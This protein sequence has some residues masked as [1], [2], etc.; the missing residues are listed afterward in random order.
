MSD[1]EL[2]HLRSALAAFLSK[3]RMPAVALD[4]TPNDVPAAAP[5]RAS[6]SPS[7]KA[8]DKTAAVKKGKAGTEP[9]ALILSTCEGQMAE[10]AKWNSMLSPT[11][12]CATQDAECA[13]WLASSLKFVVG[14]SVASSA[15]SAAL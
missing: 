2:H 12:G 13:D 15:H 1:T 7:P 3:S 11:S 8:S 14:Q 9:A 4:S 5:T 10:F 6:A